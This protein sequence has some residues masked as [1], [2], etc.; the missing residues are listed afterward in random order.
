MV[1]F[2]ARILADHHDPRHESV[3]EYLRD[4]Q[5]RDVDTFRIFC[6]WESALWSE[7]FLSGMLDEP[8]PIAPLSIH[9]VRIS[10]LRELV[11]RTYTEIKAM[12]EDDDD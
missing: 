2:V 8:E 3:L 4:R 7:K 12:P 5:H 1:Q 10:E 11:K 9:I 6:I